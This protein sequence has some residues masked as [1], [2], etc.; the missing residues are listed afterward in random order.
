MLSIMPVQSR[1]EHFGHFSPRRPEAGFLPGS[2]RVEHLRAPA[3][4]GDTYAP[5]AVRGSPAGGAVRLDS[6][7]E[8]GD[9]V[10]VFYD[11]MLA[12]LIVRGADRPLALR[13]MQQALAGWQDSG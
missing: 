12:K 1:S 13:A 6:G 3:A 8:E 7:V 9:D 10:S 2:G 11:P 5:A 4:E